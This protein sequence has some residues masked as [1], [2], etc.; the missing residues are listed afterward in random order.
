MVKDV[1]RAEALKLLGKGKRK[2]SSGGTTKAAAPD[3]PYGLIEL[4]FFIPGMITQSLN[5]TLNNN[6]SQ[7]GKDKQRWYNALF[8]PLSY[9]VNPESR[10][11]FWQIDI[12]RYGA[13]K[14]DKTNLVGGMK[15][16]EDAL[17]YLGLMRDDDP[18]SSNLDAHQII[19]KV[20]ER[21]MLIE[22][23]RGK[24]LEER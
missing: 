19:A 4:K 7:Q 15:P 23:K 21:G 18:D 11:H 6:I 2:K 3:G 8:Q 13:K 14:L 20:G 5:T 12:T 16:L 17:C 1:N 10:E 22:L 24:R 9:L